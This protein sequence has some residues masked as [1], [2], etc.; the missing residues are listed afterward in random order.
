MVLAVLFVL[1][2]LGRLLT[3]IKQTLVAASLAGT[4][5]TQKKKSKK[6]RNEKINCVADAV[7][8]LTPSPINH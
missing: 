3:I 5:N 6:N 8:V 2:I 4:I 7:F 1:A